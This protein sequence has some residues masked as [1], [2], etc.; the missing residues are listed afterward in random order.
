MNEALNDTQVWTRLTMGLGTCSNILSQHPEGRSK[1][2]A[3]GKAIHSNKRPFKQA[4]I[5]EIQQL[6][7]QSILERH[8]NR[9]ACEL[10]D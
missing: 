7:N 4:T 9:T 3:P 5:P 10:S 6:I 1:I 2:Q 8:Q